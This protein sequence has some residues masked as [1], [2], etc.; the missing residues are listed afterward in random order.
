MGDGVIMAEE[1][2]SRF[3]F[4]RAIKR[5][6]EGDVAGAL[7]DGVLACVISPVAANHWRFLATL[8]TMREDLEGATVALRRAMRLEPG[9]I[10]QELTL[11][12]LLRRSG[13]P[14]EALALVRDI[15]ERVPDDERAW[16]NLAVMC[17]HGWRDFDAAR[18]FRR[19]SCLRPDR[20]DL[21]YRDNL[22][23]PAVPRSVTDIADW[24][25]RF[26]SGINRLRRL[27][28]LLDDPAE[29][30]GPPSFYLAYHDEDDRPLMEALRRMFR[31]TA[32][33][34]THRAPHLTRWK[35]PRGGDRGIR[36][37]FVSEYLSG[38]TIGKLYQGVLRH[39]DRR[40]F[41]ITLIHTPNS[42]HDDFRDQL[43]A[44]ADRSIIL[45][46]G[47]GA[48]QQA[49]SELELDVLFYPDIGMTA[50]TYF[51]AYAR[52]APVQAVAWGH[53]DTTGLDTM[54][55][56]VSSVALEPPAADQY[57]S[58]RLVGLTRIPCCYE[59]PRAPENIP[60]RSS[61]G[62]PATGTLYGCPQTLFKL[63]P[64]FDA[65]LAEIVTL[66]PDGHI[67]FLSAR[68][69]IQ[70][71]QLR[72]RWMVNY[73]VL[74]DR[75]V[76]LPSQPFPR[77]LE[78]LGRLDVLLD[79]IHF[80]SGNTMYEAMIHGTPIVTWPGRFMRAR[81]VAAAYAQMEIPDPPVV[82]RVE[83]YAAMAASLGRDPMRREDLRRRSRV[84]AREKLFS[85][86]SVVREFEAF[87]ESAILARGAGDLLP[88][89]WRPS[90]PVEPSLR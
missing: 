46:K 26:R 72:K 40:R 29:R 19:A 74:L 57:Y 34:L 50:S 36:V 45:P 38:H 41:A 2:A 49:V 4:N 68:N 87:L 20:L 33:C 42:S 17:Q 22:L 14:G 62:L 51:L 86:M 85:D 53:P 82:E 78:L 30:L 61:W 55:Y 10:K 28:P 80:G 59:P 64:D 48:Q 76:F 39:L 60:P 67:V 73:P 75:T 11:G 27:P 47:I 9:D 16:I 63:H 66:D 81:I 52:L 12:E 70:T 65:V 1:T 58:E 89:G 88:R 8:K 90:G 43:D 54:D 23:L 83:D 56:F 24:R 7:S 31:S 84:G 3:R 6:H 32:P 77:F 25:W 15:A 21:V 79:P 13:R 71:E 44:L 5:A 35:P 69:E 18:A 37:G